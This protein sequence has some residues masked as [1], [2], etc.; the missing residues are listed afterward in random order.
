MI[1]SFSIAGTSATN[2]ALP[3]VPWHCCTIEASHYVML[4]VV[5]LGAFHEVVSC[6]V[7]ILFCQQCQHMQAFYTDWILATNFDHFHMECRQCREDMI[8]FYTSLHGFVPLKG[9]GEVAAVLMS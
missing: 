4:V 1:I 7:H 9:A 5:D 2:A 8:M 3:V 6:T